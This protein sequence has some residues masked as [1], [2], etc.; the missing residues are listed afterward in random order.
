MKNI[1]ANKRFLLITL[2][3]FCSA[4]KYYFN[5]FYLNSV[6]VLLLNSIGLLSICLFQND[7]FTLECL[8]VI[9]NEF[10]LISNY[11]FYLI[12]KTQQ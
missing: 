3:S 12:L 7:I 9:I 4:I 6:I 5:V 11:Y 2:L 10:I 8:A 1:G